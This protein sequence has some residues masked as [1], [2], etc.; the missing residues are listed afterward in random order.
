[1]KILPVTEKQ[2]RN[3][4]LLVRPPLGSDVGGSMVSELLVGPVVG[5]G[6]GGG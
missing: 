1:M 4:A 5:G 6:L 2:S 3:I